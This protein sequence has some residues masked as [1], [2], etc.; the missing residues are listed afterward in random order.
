MNYH[1]QNIAITPNLDSIKENGIYFD[2]IY[3]NGDR[4]DKGIVSILSGFPVLPTTSVIKYTNKTEQLPS[5]AKELKKEMYKTS[6]Y[7]G[8]EINFANLNSYLVSSG[9]DE[10][11]SGKNFR[12]IKFILP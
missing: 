11:I 6:F 5:I 4:T 12:T 2:N 3:A 1:F 7:Y 10:I 9:Y 8:G